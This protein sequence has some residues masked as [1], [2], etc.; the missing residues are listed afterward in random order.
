MS[1][2]KSKVSSPKVSPFIFKWM[3]NLYPPFLFGRI[4]IKHVAKDFQHVQVVVRKSIFNKN[5]S[6]SVFGG[7]MFS[8][9][10]P[11]FALMYWQNFAHQYNR[12]VKVWL[13]S[14]EI[15][16]KRPAM[17]DL[18]LDFYISQ[19]DVEAA[20]YAIE[21]NGKYTKVHE[22]ELKDKNGNVSA[23]VK[24]EPYVGLP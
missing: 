24:L 7:T 21:A 17:T 8:A 19:E 3:L 11:F 12:K 6:Q 9:A 5:L 1:L 18:T 10:D 2:K 13:K 16:Y 15:Q 23:V 22:V 20:K 4:R 14:A